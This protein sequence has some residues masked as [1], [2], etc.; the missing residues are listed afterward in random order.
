MEATQFIPFRAEIHCSK[1]EKQLLMMLQPL[2]LEI[3][4]HCP[5]CGHNLTYVVRQSIRT[6]LSA[7]AAYTG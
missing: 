4:L 1:C 7:Q 3:P 2:H 5:N 6:H